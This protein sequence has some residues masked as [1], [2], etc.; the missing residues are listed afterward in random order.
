MEKFWRARNFQR[1][2]N[3]RKT[4]K[5]EPRPWTREEDVAVLAHDILDT[6][7]SKKIERSVQAIQIR[8]CRLKS[9]QKM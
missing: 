8:R 6:E 1:K 3:Y 7:L 4:A 5:Y 2:I 9:R